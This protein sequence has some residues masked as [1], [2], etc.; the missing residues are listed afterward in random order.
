MIDRNNDRRHVSWDLETTGFAWDAQITVSGFW[1]PG[2][3]GH[4]E[5]V[6][7]TDGAA[8]DADQHETHLERVSD[9]T[10]AITPADD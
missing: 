4:A 9:A 1:F 7:N 6:V 8:I 10:V 5:L 2:G 3:N